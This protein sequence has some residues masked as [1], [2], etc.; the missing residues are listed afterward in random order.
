MGRS[1][2]F[3][4]GDWEGRVAAGVDG[5]WCHSSSGGC[6]CEHGCRCF[7]GPVSSHQS[8]VIMSH[9]ETFTSTSCDCATVLKIGY[10][11]HHTCHKIIA[12][13]QKLDVGVADLCAS[14]CKK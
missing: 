12:L 4:P 8:K 1:S 7:P 6:E 9:L 5:T 11:E 10:S 3:E 2:A 14:Q 13:C